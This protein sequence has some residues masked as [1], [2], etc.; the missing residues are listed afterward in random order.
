MHEYTEKEEGKEEGQC[1]TQK[2]IILGFPKGEPK[3]FACEC[4]G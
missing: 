2:P 4:V 1:L 3:V